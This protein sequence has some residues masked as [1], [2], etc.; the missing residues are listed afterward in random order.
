MPL[1]KGKVGEVYKI[2]SIPENIATSQRLMELGLLTGTNVI[3]K[4]K[5]F[6]SGHMIIKLNNWDLAI[7]NKLSKLIKVSKA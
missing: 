6:L 3:I 4:E 2:K 1:S 5:L 7:D